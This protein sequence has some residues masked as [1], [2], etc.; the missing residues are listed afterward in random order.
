MTGTN[1]NIE[2]QI[3]IYNESTYTVGS[4][5][6][7][8]SYDKVYFGD[9]AR[10]YP[11]SK[12]GI[13][14]IQN[15]EI[16]NKCLIVGSGGST[17]IHKHSSARYKSQLL[18]CCCNSVFCITLPDLELKWVKVL[19]I[20][21][22]FQI[23]EHNNNFIIHGEI[24]VSKIDSNGKLKWQFGGQDIFVSIDNQEEFKI[25]EDGIL[26]CDFANTFYK[27]DFDGKL[28]WS[29]N[30]NEKADNNR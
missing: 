11:T 27:I 17:T 3:N 30:K 23:F 15:G 20:V 25:E 21:T 24:Q 28:I 14:I 6:N 22:C 1:N 18:I 12:H 16:V 7:V 26:L 8:N 13:S 5:D 2:Y 19:D 29:K 9:N 10:E 4:T